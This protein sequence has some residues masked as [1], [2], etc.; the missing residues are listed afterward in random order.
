MV[1]NRKANPVH[2]M[3]GLKSQKLLSSLNKAR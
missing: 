2:A 3:I 1:G